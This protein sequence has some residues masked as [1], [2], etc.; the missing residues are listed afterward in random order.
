MAKFVSFEYADGYATFLSL[1][2]LSGDDVLLATKLAC[3]LS[4]TPSLF[5]CVIKISLP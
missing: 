3:A 1:D 4:M 2:E 5:L